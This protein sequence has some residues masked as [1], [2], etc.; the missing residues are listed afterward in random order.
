M[1]FGSVDSLT[2]LFTRLVHAHFNS[3]SHG[4]FFVATI[5]NEINAHADLDWLE[6]IAA[7]QFASLFIA[8]NFNLYFSLIEEFPSHGARCPPIA[9]PTS[10]Y[11]MFFQSPFYFNLNRE[12]HRE[13]FLTSKF[14]IRKNWACHVFPSFFSHIAV[15][16]KA[17][18]KS[19]KDENGTVDDF[20]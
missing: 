3:L 8:G 10:Y 16:G 17:E 14:V 18:N 6:C 5:V 12:I 15:L 11:K 2:F 20:F 9:V 1:K 13:F 7:R 4:W 19:T